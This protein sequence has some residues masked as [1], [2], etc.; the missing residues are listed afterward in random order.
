MTTRV[1]TGGVFSGAG[2]AA[3]VL[4]AH[5]EQIRV[6][7]GLPALLPGTLN[8][9]LPAPYRL[10]PDFAIGREAW[11]HTEDVFFQRCQVA[12]LQGLIM[13]TST[14][15]HGLSVLEVMAEV[16]LRDMLHLQDGEAV[17]VSVPE[18]R[19]RVYAEHSGLAPYVR[20]AQQEDRILLVHFPFDPNSR[21]RHL[22][23]EATPAG[24]QWRDLN[25]TWGELS[26]KGITWE[27]L[28]PSPMLSRIRALIG[29]DNRRDALHVAS[30]YESGCDLFLTRDSDILNHA[31][32]L[33]ALLGFRLLHP[34]R[35]EAEVRQL[36]DG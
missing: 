26:A 1:L 34:E 23:P 2:I 8:I 17:T 15:Y 35:D 21:S 31:A 33:Q 6:V 25:A 22:T 12:D 27:D 18:L 7:V 32:A 13:R 4:E 11:S 14:N 20:R 19:L 9:R 30:A 29:P 28:N 5:I 10:V 3:R 16:R 24:A 36:L